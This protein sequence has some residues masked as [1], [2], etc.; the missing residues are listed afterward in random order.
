[1]VRV[2]QTCSRLQLL[3]Q[4]SC[5]IDRSGTQLESAEKRE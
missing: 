1:M 4:L 2:D 5:R 3:Q